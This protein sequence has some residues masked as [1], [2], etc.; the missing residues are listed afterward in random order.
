MQNAEFIRYLQEAELLRDSFI[1]NIT[2]NF[3]RHMSLLLKLT[4]Q[5]GKS[6]MIHFKGISEYLFF[7]NDVS[8]ERFLISHYKLFKIDKGFYFS[9]DPFSESEKIESEDNNY[10]I[11]SEI[12]LG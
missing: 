7:D 4:T 12:S 3:S 2:I 8:S 11:F 10:I 9:F 1:E 6:L 5:N